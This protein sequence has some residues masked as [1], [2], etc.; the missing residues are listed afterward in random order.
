MVSSFWRDRSIAVAIHFLITLTVTFFV[1]ALIFFIWF[2]VGLEN[3]MG[4]KALFLLVTCSDLI[5][6]PLISLVIFNRKKSR[7]H[8]IADYVVVGF[9][10]L[11]ALFYGVSVVAESRPVF[12]G[13]AVDR[14]EIVSAL[15]LDGSDLKAAPNPKYKIKSWFGPQFVYMEKPITTAENTELLFSALGGKDIQLHPKYY[16]DYSEAVAEIQKKC[17]PLSSLD[18]KNILTD[19]QSKAWSEVAADKNA[20]AMCFLMVHHRFGFSTAIINKE[21]GCPV[22]YLPIDPY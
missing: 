3:I 15:E 12:I 21:T 22:K 7:R 6:G 17:R 19:E 14:M 9:V 13:F 2:P 5:L 4:G 18:K 10:Q 16:R 20:S 8:L 1:A 11:S